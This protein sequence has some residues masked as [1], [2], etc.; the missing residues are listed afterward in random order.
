MHSA[1]VK[2]LILIDTEGARVARL[3]DAT[4][5]HV[6]DMDASTEDVL[7]TIQGVLPSATGTAPEWDAALAGHSAA[8]RAQ[9]QVF[10]LPL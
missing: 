9:A 6:M 2:F 4:R 8:E 10:T 7:V 3:F 1:P 5:R